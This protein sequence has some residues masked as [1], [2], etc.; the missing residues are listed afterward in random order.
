[1][2]SFN[3]RISLER[4]LLQSCALIHSTL[5]STPTV[6][7]RWEDEMA[8]KRADHPFTFICCYENEVTH[9]CLCACS[10]LLHFMYGGCG[11]DARGSQS[12]FP[13]PSVAANLAQMVRPDQLPNM[14]QNPSAYGP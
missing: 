8:R 4:F 2:R 7:C 6:H 1:M 11:T 13:R 9:C 12:M 5:M 10:S 3:A 14:P